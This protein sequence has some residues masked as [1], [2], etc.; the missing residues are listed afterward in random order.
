MLCRGDHLLQ[1]CPSIPKVLEAWSTG[2]HRPLS[3]AFGDHVGDKPSTSK[4]QGK[5]GKVNFPCNLCEGNHPIHLFT[6]MDEASKVLENLIASQ[7]RLL[8]GYR[9]ISLD[10]LLV[11]HL[12]KFIFGQPHSL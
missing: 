6:L 8:T 11:D 10:P 3:L 4:S 9:N 7:L 5:K 1:N 12:S 2:S